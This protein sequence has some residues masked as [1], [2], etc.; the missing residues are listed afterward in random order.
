VTTGYRRS[1]ISLFVAGDHGMF[2]SMDLELGGSAFIVTGGTDGLGAA[3]A[4]RLVVEGAHVAVCGR[5]IERLRRVEA[6]LRD[7]AFGRG[8]G[9]DIIAVRADVTVPTDLE[10]L[11]TATVEHFGGLDGVVNNAGRSSAGR[12]DALDD[13]EWAYDLDSKVMAAVR[14]IRLAL[15]H[16]RAAGSGAIVNVLNTGARAPAAASLPTTA[17]RAAGLAVTKSLSKELGPD[18]IRVNAIMIGLVDSGQWRRRSEA[19]GRS[20][21]DLYSEMARGIPLGRVGRSEEFADLAAYLLSR[22]ASYVTGCAVNLDGGAS[23]VP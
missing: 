3:L 10:G 15:P 5:D 11:V 18:N 7:P 1:R 4:E 9:G 20:L 23:P 21:D 13:D 17:S 12:I 6:R 19:T 2:R 16:L 8:D 22:R 14:L